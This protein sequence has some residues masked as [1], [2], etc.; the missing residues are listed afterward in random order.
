MKLYM[1][2]LSYFSAS[3]KHGYN[4]WYIEIPLVLICWVLK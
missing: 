4:D 1:Y 3:I 2:V